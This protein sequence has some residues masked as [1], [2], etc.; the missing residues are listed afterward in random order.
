MI[1]QL[2]IHA[3]VRD[4][5]KVRKPVV[6]LES[7]VIS[8]GLPWPDNLQTV[9]AMQQAIVAEGATPAVIGIY[10]GRVG[11]GLDDQVLEYFA[12]ADGIAKASRRDIAALL[13][14]GKDGAT[15]V[16]GTMM[17]AAMAGIRVFATGGIGGV[18][19]RVEETLD[20]SADITE[21][22]RTEVAVVCSGA[23]S[24]LDLPKTME[25]LETQGVPVIGYGT[26]TFP[27][28]YTRDS[29]LCLDVRVDTPEAAARIVRTHQHLHAGGMIVANPIPESASLDPVELEGWILQ[30]EADADAQGMTGKALTPFMLDRL[31]TLSGGRTLAANKSL[32]QDNACVAARI[33]VALASCRT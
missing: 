3:S 7:T 27:A 19:R 26:N 10:R 18:H 32:L 2:D 30:A 16:A 1:E 28:F 21:L 20:V 13:A 8:H 25:V 22:G 11:I 9:R 4:A 29:G 17:C 31:S 24:I 23:K 14:L 12:R 33:A 5:L 15:T 6:A